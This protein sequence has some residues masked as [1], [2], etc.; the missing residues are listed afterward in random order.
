ML[1]TIPPPLET[2]ALVD[3]AVLYAACLRDP[4]FGMHDEG[5]GSQW[6]KYAGDRRDC[7]CGLDL[8]RAG[9]PAVLRRLVSAET[10]ASRFR[11]ALRSVAPHGRPESCSCQACC[12]VVRALAEAGNR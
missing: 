6:D 4:H 11:A 10:R 8:I 1:D 7:D 12:A 2:D 5:C 9:L 3:A